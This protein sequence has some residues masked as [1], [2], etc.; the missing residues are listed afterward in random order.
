MEQDQ[1]SLEPGDSESV[2]RTPS[3][4][5]HFYEKV[6]DHLGNFSRKTALDIENKPC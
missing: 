3:H 1:R 5:V 4:Y 2:Q 6:I